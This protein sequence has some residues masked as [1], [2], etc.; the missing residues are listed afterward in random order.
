MRSDLAARRSEPPGPRARAAASVATVLAGLL[1]L[2]CTSPKSFVVLTLQSAD[3]APIMDVTEVIVVVT[4]GATLTKTL[5]YPPPRDAASITIDQGTANDLSVSFSGGQSGTVNLAVT[6][7]NAAGCAVGGGQ[8]TALIRKG[9]IATASV[10]LAVENDCQSADGGIDA[11]GGDAPFPGC[12]PAMPA[13]GAG[14]TCQVN[15]DKRVGECV[16]GGTGGPGAPCTSNADCA[17]GSQCFDYSGT[18]CA[19]KVCLRFCNGDDMCMMSDTDA[20]GGDVTGARVDAGA[21]DASTSDG[22][23]APPSATPAGGSALGVE[24]L[25][26]GPV[27]CSGVATTYHTCTFACD[28]RP[29]AASSSSTGCPT[30]LACLIVGNMDQV[31][32]ACAE[33]TRTGTDGDSCTG[34]IDCAPGFI[35]N[36]MGGSSTCRAVCRCD[37]Q[38]LTCS[39]ANDCGG[40]RICSA[41]TNDTTFGVCL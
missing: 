2:S 15:C 16:T 5:I 26:Q 17:P 24:S 41:L 20:G 40:G 1:G 8:T 35:C 9:D 21:T 31:D 28:P 18:G 7:R 22:A 11:A 30:G 27:E 12:D 3:P 13:C 19:V 14:K 39:A 29:A 38:G 10:D 25:C 32:C 33:P 6:V 23:D 37:A 36:L 4:Q 34:S